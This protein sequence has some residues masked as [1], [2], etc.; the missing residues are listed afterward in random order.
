LKAYFDFKE[1]LETLL[2]R[3]VDLVE[4]RELRNPCLEASIEQS[5]EPV[6]EA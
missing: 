3:S 5:R 2:G 6:F 1:P 4:P